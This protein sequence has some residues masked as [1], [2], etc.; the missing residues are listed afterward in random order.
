MKFG[1]LKITAK[2]LLV[3]AVMSIYGVANELEIEAT[4]PVEFEN[5]FVNIL[6][7]SC[8]DLENIFQ[9]KEP[10]NQK[11]DI[12]EYTDR[13]PVFEEPELILNLGVTV[14]ES[15]DIINKFHVDL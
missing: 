14:V 8:S 1:K 5:R 7:S 15:E 2:L 6:E 4:F 9:Y 12:K 10:L 13:T 3:C 11:D